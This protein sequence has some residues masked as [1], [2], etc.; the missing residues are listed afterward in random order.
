MIRNFMIVS[1]LKFPIADDSIKNNLLS[2]KN[3]RFYL[4]LNYTFKKKTTREN[5][6]SYYCF[7][8]KNSEISLKTNIES[9]FFFPS[10]KHE[11]KK[12]IG[13]KSP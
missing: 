11:G 10:T 6:C 5:I 13:E 3:L 7:T 2:V 12:R 8:D 9:L 1:C 4:L